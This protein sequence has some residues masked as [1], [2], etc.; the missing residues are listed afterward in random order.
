MKPISLSGTS[1]LAKSLT[2]EI[3]LP[4]DSRYPSLRR[5]RNHAVNMHP[6]V[7]IRCA[8]R[9]DVQRAIEFARRHHLATAIRAGGHS[10]AGHGTCENGLVI[11]LSTM[12]RAQVDP[13]HA[14]IRIEAGVMAGEL[15]CLTH[16]TRW[17]CL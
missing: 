8:T 2:G 7:I 13:I 5:V 17:R 11:D 4:D 3:V 16:H 9:E 15:D 10:F 1:K 14:R 12:K 6:A